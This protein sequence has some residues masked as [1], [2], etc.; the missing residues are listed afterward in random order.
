MT[1]PTF[2]PQPGF[3]EQNRYEFGS[4]SNELGQIFND[5]TKLK[6]ILN[7]EQQLLESEVVELEKARP[8]R[9]APRDAQNEYLT[10]AAQITGNFEL[11]SRI[12]DRLLGDKPQ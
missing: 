12:R 1:Q 3:V 4:P 2:E 10:K 11:L 9:L 7:E 6:T 8:S 5:D